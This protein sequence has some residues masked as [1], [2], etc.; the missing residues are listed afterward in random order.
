MKGYRITEGDV[1]AG[2]Q[3]RMEVLVEKKSSSTG[4][5]WKVLGLLLLMAL[6]IGGARLYIWYQ[7]E[8]S[9]PT[10]RI[11]FCITEFNLKCVLFRVH[12]F[13]V[14]RLSP[15]DA[16]RTDSGANHAEPRGDRR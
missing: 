12:L 6:S 5:M 15:P 4:W 14:Y 11:I 16:L 2:P 1:E 10:V 3:E 13:N 9:E 8:R 7:L